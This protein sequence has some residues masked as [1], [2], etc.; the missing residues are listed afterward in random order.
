MRRTIR[1]GQLLPGA[2]AVMAIPQGAVSFNVYTSTLGALGALAATQSLSAINTLP[3]TTTV[4]PGFDVGLGAVGLVG[5]ARGLEILN[6]GG[7]NADGV[8]VSFTLAF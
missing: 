8:R 6:T 3:L 7:A 4:N 1:I 2:G 5:G